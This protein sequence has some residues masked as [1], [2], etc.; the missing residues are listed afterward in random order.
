MFSSNAMADG[1]EKKRKS[2]VILGPDASGLTELSLDELEDR[3]RRSV[4]NDSCEDDFF[5]RVRGKAKD[6]AKEIISGAMA[7]AERIKAG[8]A[9]EGRAEGMAQADSEIEAMLGEKARLLSEILEKAQGGGKALWDEYRQDIVALTVLAVE[10]VLAVE[11]EMRHKD[12]LAALLDE[13]LDNIDSQRNLLVKVHPEDAELMSELL[14]KAVKS[15]GAL[16]NWK[17]KPDEGVGRGG[18]VLE[19]DQGMVDNSFQ[20]RREIIFQVFE[21]LGLAEDPGGKDS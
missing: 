19:S 12:V 2:K 1:P 4:W 6:L 5:N 18:V 8:A 16:K 20:A 7:E 9:E 13:A 14:D 15:H 3:N 17:I 10:K 21:K 11:M